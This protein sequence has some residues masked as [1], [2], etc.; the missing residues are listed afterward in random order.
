M[1]QIGCAGWLVTFTYEFLGFQTL[2][3]VDPWGVLVH[4]VVVFP[5]SSDFLIK[6]RFA[7]YEPNV[8]TLELFKD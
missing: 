2:V 1:G 4:A 3:N 8:L 6:S 5:L 7:P